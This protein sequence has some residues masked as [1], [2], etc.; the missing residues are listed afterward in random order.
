MPTI[1]IA[2]MSS[3]VATGLRMKILEG[4][5]YGSPQRRGSSRGS[6]VGPALLPVLVL[7]V[8]AALAGAGRPLRAL[9]DEHLAAVLEPVRPVD[10]DEVARIDA[11]AMLTRSPSVSPSFT[12]LAV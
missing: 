5:I 2:A 1:R 11:N 4:L 8:G 3:V 12:S 6:V 7:A 9:L 10:D